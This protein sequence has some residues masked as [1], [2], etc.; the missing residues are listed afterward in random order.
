MNK[1]QLSF[2]LIASLIIFVSSSSNP[3]NGRTGAPGEGL[4]TDCHNNSNPNGFDGSVVVSGLPSTIQANTSYTLTVTNSNPNGLATKGGFQIVALDGSN[5]DAG[6]MA[7][8]GSNSTI[9]FS[10]GRTYLEHNPSTNYS[11]DM[12]SWTVDWISPAGPDNEPI[13]IYASAVIANGASGNSGDLTVTSVQSGTLMASGGTNLTITVSGSNVSCNGNSD[14]SASA[15]ASGGTAPY[16]YDWSNGQTGTTITNLNAGNYSVTAT[17]ANGN[18]GEESYTVTEPDVLMGFIVNQTNVGC[19]GGNTGSATVDA[20]GG[21]SPYLYLWPDGSMAITNNNLSAGTFD[22]TV[23]DSNNCTDLI[24]ITISQGA[25]F[26]VDV[27]PDGGIICPGSVLNLSALPSGGFTPYN[28]LW[29]NGNTTQS[30]T[31]ANAGT[32]SVTVTDN[33]GC[34]SGDTVLVTSHPVFTI[35]V[36]GTDE[37][38]PG[39]NDGTATLNIT[40]GNSN[41][42]YNWS[43]GG[44]TQT[45]TNLT[46]GNYSVTV[47]DTNTNCQTMGSTTIGTGACDVNLTLIPSNPDCANSNDGFIDVFISGGLGPFTYLWSTGDTIL[48]LGFLD[49]GEYSL[50]VTD[51]LGCTDEQVAEIVCPDPIILEFQTD[52]IT[53]SNPTA[54]ANVIVTGGTG[55]YDYDW[56]NGSNGNFQCGLAAEEYTVTVTSSEGCIGISSFMIETTDSLEIV[57]AL[58][59]ESVEGAADGKAV[60]F[61]MGGVEPYQYLWSTGETGNTISNLTEGLYSLTVTDASGCTTVEN[62]NIEVSVCPF[63]IF[64]VP[65]NFDCANTSDGIIAVDIVPDPGVPLTFTWS[66][67]STS[68]TLTGA[69][70][71]EYCVTITIANQCSISDCITIDTPDEILVDIVEVQSANG[72]V[73]EGFIDISISGG[74]PFSSATEPYIV[75]WFDETNFEIGNEE[76]ISDLLPGTY[77]YEVTDS[78]GCSVCCVPIVVQNALSDIDLQTQNVSINPNPFKDVIKIHRED[79]TTQEYTI[80]LRSWDGRVIATE[81]IKDWNNHEYNWYQ[82]NLPEGI[83][84]LS[85]NDGTRNYVKKMVK[86]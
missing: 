53:C 7:N 40:N 8:P 32:Y 58:T 14:G 39:A 12:I 79:I 60:A 5:T 42:N 41:Y 78:L 11:N 76:D 47:T 65:S 46:P 52:T 36:T 71:A 25:P 4:C 17:D 55:P 2:L 66:N 26:T 35:D 83:Y 20:V 18:T 21:T 50:T 85:L 38:V 72:N 86:Y 10:G 1:I 84:L 77:T 22:V 33:T 74:T 57:L 48:N 80:S 24:N 30:I 63:D 13:N 70:V 6:T 31:I 19:S 82:P 67:G 54:C 9:T 75:K 28:Y 37:S 15:S 29:S 73:A 69:L 62:F 49:C 81:I 61:V 43:N 23:T 51:V 45:I 64:L 68:D 16:M 27:I 56:S 3:P 59:D 34:E 44:T